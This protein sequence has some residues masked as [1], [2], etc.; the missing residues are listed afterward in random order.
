[1]SPA[2]DD[3]TT[4]L[5][6]SAKK[7]LKQAQAQ[8][9]KDKSDYTIIPAGEPLGRSRKDRG[10]HPWHAR[11]AARQEKLMQMHPVERAVAAYT[12][13]VSD[14]GNACW[15]TKHFT[16]DIATRQ[17]RAPE[18]IVGLPYDTAVDTWAIACIVFEL[19]TGDYLFDP[20][21]DPE[22]RH[23][24][25]E[26]HLALMRE[27]LGPFPKKFL[28]QG[29]HSREFFTKKGEFIHIRDLQHWPLHNVL[30][31][32]YAMSSSEATLIADTLLMPMLQISPAERAS[33]ADC[34]KSPWLRLTPSDI[35]C[36]YRDYG[37]LEELDAHVALEALLFERVRAEE[38]HKWVSATRFSESRLDR[39]LRKHCPYMAWLRDSRPDVDM[40]AE[41]ER[42]RKEAGE[43]PKHGRKVMTLEEMNAVVE[44][45]CAERVQAMV[46]A[47]DAV[48][49]KEDG[50]ADAVDAKTET[51]EVKKVEQTEEPSETDGVADADTK[52]EEDVEN[53]EASDKEEEVEATVE[54]TD[55]AE[56]EAVDEDVEALEAQMEGMALNG[57]SA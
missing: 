34:L 21:A 33:A 43:P 37:L 49:S 24:R 51:E 40:D 4:P 31:D 53:V 16:D 15:T 32:K 11:R 39:H 36:M 2:F 18:V 23:S 42:L 28:T 9:K 45:A 30:T 10:P 8:E 46:E 26:D 54:K 41:I 19:I 1:M 47:H 57:D 25:N 12:V 20:K 38:V 56:D 5:S 55:A 3:R 13:K 29:R 50:T 35:S 22:G 6:R 27:L 44:Q 7:A 14:L 48:M 52:V 17:Y